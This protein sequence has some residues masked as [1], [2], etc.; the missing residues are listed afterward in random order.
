MKYIIYGMKKMQNCIGCALT[1][2][3]TNLQKIQAD[4][5]IMHA[6]LLK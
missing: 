3:T 2:S 5:K 4:A 6:M 1:I